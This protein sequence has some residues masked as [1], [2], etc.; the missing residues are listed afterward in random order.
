M[1]HD[2]PF[3]P[4]MSSW[5]FSTTKALHCYHKS[6]YLPSN[7]ILTYQSHCITSS[8]LKAN[9]LQHQRTTRLQFNWYFSQSGY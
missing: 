3:Q 1:G 7:G 2:F 8:F 9:K 6:T 4:T 5:E